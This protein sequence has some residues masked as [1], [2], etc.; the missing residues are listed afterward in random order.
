MEQ[1]NALAGQGKSAATRVWELDAWRGLCVW[2]M[3]LDHAMYDLGFFFRDVWAAHP[4]L[5]NLSALCDFAHDVYWPS[6]PRLVFR[7]LVL[8]SFI[9]LCGISCSFSRSNLWRGIRLLIVALLLSLVT[10]AADRLL[11]VRDM[12]TVRFGVLHMLAIAI[13]AYHLVH[14]FSRNIVF[15]IGILLIAMGLY[16]HYHPLPGG[17][18]IGGVLGVSPASFYSADYFPLLP[19]SGYLLVGAVLGGRLYKNRRSRFPRGGQRIWQRA[20][21]FTG[22]H[23]LLFY[24]LHQPILYA[25]FT[26]ITHVAG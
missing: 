25:V 3:I 2:L 5:Q 6:W 17:W 14:R 18:M 19:W 7:A 21:S 15:F 16:F 1:L 23:A 24:V 9:G 22:R 26:V 8:A 13:L 12:L 10:W 11:G 4:V 20:L